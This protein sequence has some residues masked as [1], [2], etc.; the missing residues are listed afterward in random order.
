L[1]AAVAI[2]LSTLAVGPARAD[3]GAAV[4]SIIDQQI[5]AFR[6]DDG[7][8][9]YSFAA[10]SIRQIFPSPDVFMSMVRSGYQPVYR[11]QSVTYGR[12][13]EDS[14]TVVQEVFV[15]GPDGEPYVALYSLEKQADG[16]WKI[17]G[18]RIAKAPGESA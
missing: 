11:P 4:R 18:C 8:T 3:D 1:L 5:A 17:T 6:R 10:P 16:S 9:A 12:L 7:A 15:V 13:R 2:V 14:G